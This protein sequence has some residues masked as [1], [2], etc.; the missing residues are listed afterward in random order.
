MTKAVILG[1]VGLLAAAARADTQT[2]GAAQYDPAQY[3]CHDSTFLC[4]IVAGEGLSYC[5]GAC[6]SKYM[7]S[8]TNNALAQLPRLPDGSAFTLAA[9]NP[10]NSKVDGVAVNACGFQWNVGGS[11][12]SYC[13]EQ[14]GSCPAGN[15]TVVTYGGG[16]T[17]LSTNVPGGQALYVDAKGTVGY[18]QAHS[19]AMP[20]NATLPGFAA[21]ADGGGLVNIASG[22][23]GWAACPPTAAGGGGGA[24]AAYTLIALTA[25]NKKQYS[26]CIPVNLKIKPVAKGTVGAWQYT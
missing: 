1:L 2:C 20:P 8:C 11:T 12:C 26:Y 6:Y 21:Y 4:P 15:T 14:V 25:D 17:G 13:P 22:G 24:N 18:T 23:Y 19:A 3:V 10:A 16:S 9:A 7:Y 5:S